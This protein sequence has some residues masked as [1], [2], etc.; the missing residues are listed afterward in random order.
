MFLR[1]RRQ[2][3][4][5]SLPSL[6][7]TQSLPVVVRDC[8]SATDFLLLARNRLALTPVLRATEKEAPQQSLMQTYSL[9]ASYQNSSPRSLER[10][11]MKGLIPRPVGRYCRS[12]RIK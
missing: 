12:W 1:R 5:F 2:V 4:L 11:K 8:S 10:M 3:S 7:S 9:V 6:T